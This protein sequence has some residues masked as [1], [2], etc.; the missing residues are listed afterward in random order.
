MNT[1]NCKIERKN[2]FASGAYLIAKI[3]QNKVDKN[4]LY[5]ISAEAPSFIL[6]FTYKNID[7]ETEIIY[8]VG[9]LSKLTYF[10]GELDKDEYAGLWVSLLEPLLACGDWFLSPDSFVLNID[11]LYYDKRKKS[12]V[13]VYVPSVDYNS[14]KN[15]FNDMVAALSKI[16]T[17]SD[18]ALE[19]KML[20]SIV[21]NSSPR[22]FLEMLKDHTSQETKPPVNERIVRSDAQIPRSAGTVRGGEKPCVPA[23]ADLPST[24]DLPIFGVA[25]NEQITAKREK[26]EPGRFK[27]FGTKSK[28]KKEPKPTI[29][30]ESESEINDDFIGHDQRLS[31]RTE[32][33]APQPQ[34]Q[35]AV[36]E[37][38]DSIPIVSQKVSLKCVGKA[39]L[40]Q[41]IDVALSEGDIFSI[42]RYDASVGKPQSSFEFDKKTKAVSRRHAVIE[43]EGEAYMI[44]D[45]ASRA[46]TFVDGKKLPPNTPYQLSAGTRVSFGNFGA[47]YIWEIS[48][49]AGT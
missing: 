2:D 46:G 12:A 10:Q 15:A 1:V 20:R 44:I 16:I 38:T 48:Y 11:Y 21:E 43:R 8:D 6:P 19:N 5:T 35:T 32:N 24:D 28:K 39:E 45:L 4:A 25:K 18:T 13:Y 3:L 41:L 14:D 37:I 29:N 27:L 33:I 40:P 30:S 7:G 9:N 49:H 22:E 17:V 23:Q 31:E 42:G 47:D 36:T 34:I 26:K